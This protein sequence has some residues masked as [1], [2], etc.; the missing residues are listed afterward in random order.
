VFKA[1]PVTI[2]GGILVLT[3]LVGPWFSFSIVDHSVGNYLYFDMSPFFL[4]IKV[5]KVNDPFNEITSSGCHYFYGADKS[6]IGIVCIIGAIL[7][8][9]GGGMDRWKL[10]LVGGITVLIATLS[11]SMCL[12]GYLPGLSV[13]W[14]S[15]IS[16]FGAIVIIS[17]ISLGLLYAKLGSFVRFTRALISNQFYF[18]VCECVLII[19]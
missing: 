16:A 2:I 5:S 7:S 6:L 19:V 12:P 9:F 10:S 4:N 13:N 17:S 14:G 11:F 3:G 15:Y 8:F 1:N 18:E